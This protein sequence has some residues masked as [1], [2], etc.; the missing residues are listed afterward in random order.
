[1]KV[2]ITGAGGMLGQ[3]L[4]KAL[5]RHHEVIP[6]VTDRSGAG[7]EDAPAILNESLVNRVFTA[8]RPEVVIH[9]AAYTDVDGAETNQAEAHAVNVL[10]TARIAE[11]S[12]NA[13]AVLFYISTDYVFDGLKS[14]SYEEADAPNPIGIYGKTKLAAEREL[15]SRYGLNGAIYIIRTSWLF[16]AGGKN[17]FRSIL[18]LASERDTLRVVNDQKGAPTYTK[19]LAEV[20]QVLIEKAK[21]K[22]GCHIYHLANAGVTTWYEAAARLLE[23]AHFTGKLLPLRSDELNRPAKRPA[24]SVLNM[25]KI[26]KAFG[27][28]MRSWETALDEFWNEVLRHEWE[29]Q[30]K[31]R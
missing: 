20:F 14:G 23:K 16:G 3:D 25:S 17:F 31:T 18:R 30:I 2:L 24:N 1:M 11:A 19:D 27:I 12:V 5:S 22:N 21:R 29:S 4:V 26:Q 8:T 13:K 9:A 28:R 6:L 7:T 10:G 15:S